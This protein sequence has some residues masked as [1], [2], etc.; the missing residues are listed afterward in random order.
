SLQDALDYLRERIAALRPD[1]IILIGDD[2]DENFREDNLPQFA[3]YTGEEVQVEA[4]S[5]G[6]A[7]AVRGHVEGP[8]PYPCDTVLARAIHEGVVEAEFDL[9]SSTHF[10]EDRLWSHAHVQILS[11]MGLLTRPVPIVPI[12]VNAI[13]VPAPT[14]PRCYAFGEAMRRVIEAQP[15][16][17]RVLVYASGGLSHYTAGFPWPN[18]QGP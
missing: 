5:G 7:P 13:H 12:F 15:D 17:K 14:P 16:D 9:S 10:P 3:I 6:H 1:T 2:Q 8:V 18:Y 4:R 11:Y